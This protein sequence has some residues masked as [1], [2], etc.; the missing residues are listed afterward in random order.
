[1]LSQFYD[2]KELKKRDYN[3][4]SNEEYMM[5][6]VITHIMTA[7]TIVLLIITNHT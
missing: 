2:Y 1:M 3:S 5:Q 4:K 6:L 7:T